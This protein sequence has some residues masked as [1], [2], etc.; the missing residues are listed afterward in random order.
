MSTAP[1][2]LSARIDRLFRA[3]HTRDQPELT[4]ACIAA[5]ASAMS[6][7]PITADLIEQLRSG[8][9]TS[10]NPD[11]LKAIAKCF[12]APATYLTDVDCSKFDAQLQVLTAL[13]DARLNWFAFRGTGAISTDQL[14]QVAEVLDKLADEEA[15]A[16]PPLVAGVDE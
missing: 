9:S 11:V 16:E 15:E 10:A 12:D 13:R 8:D 2:P 6:G 5:K 7:E 1:I 4:N 14:E 3:M